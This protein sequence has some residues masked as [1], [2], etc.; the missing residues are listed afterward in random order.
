[1]VT[2]QLY[3][4]GG[5]DNRELRVACRKGFRDF[6][7][8]AGFAGRMPKIIACGGRDSALDHFSKALASGFNPMLLVDAEGPVTAQGTWQHVRDR[9]GWARPVG[10]SDGQCHLMVQSMESWFLA[11][12]D[13]LASYYGQGFQRQSL[14][15]NPNIEAIPKDDVRVGLGQ[16]ARATAKN[17]Y[18]KGRDS[19]PILGGIDLGKVRTASPYAERFVRSMM[20]IMNGN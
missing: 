17:G 1:M 18:K 11:D 2:V 15:Q 20:E 8:R 10:A 4:E 16:A 12:V 14:P 7:D 6:L 5:G 3:V 13:A 9:D 19:F